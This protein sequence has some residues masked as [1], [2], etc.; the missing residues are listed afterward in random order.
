MTDEQRSAVMEANQ[1]LQKLQIEREKERKVQKSLALRSDF[2]ITM[3]AAIVANSNNRGV[4]PN[5]EMMAKEAIKYADAL[6]T[7]LSK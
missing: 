6:L 3:L 5:P 1:Q 4:L 7:E 2:S